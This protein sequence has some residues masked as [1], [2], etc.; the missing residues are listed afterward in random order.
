M[1]QNEVWEHI[2]GTKSIRMK[3]VTLG[4]HEVKLPFRKHSHTVSMYLTTLIYLKIL[5]CTSQLPSIVLS[6]IKRKRS[7]SFLTLSDR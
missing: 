7:K 1:L 6:K 5:E 3:A 4:K 2:L